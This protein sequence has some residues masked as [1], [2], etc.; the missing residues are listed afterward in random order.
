MSETPHAELTLGG[1]L[2]VAGLLFVLWIALIGRFDVQEWAVG[3]VLSILVVLLASPRLGVFAGLRLTPS[4][5][6]HF[7]SWLGF[8]LIALLR[9]NIDMARRVLSPSLPLK[10]GFVEVRTA[11]SSPLGKIAL[12]NSIT[13]TPGTLAVDVEDDRLLVHWVDTGDMTDV[14]AATAEI[15][16]GFERH[17]KGFLK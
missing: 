9:A 10:P 15:A 6:L 2:F 5:P 7:L 16:A 14:D 17:L 8:F 4:A 1:R 12:A 3:A 11:L 13:L